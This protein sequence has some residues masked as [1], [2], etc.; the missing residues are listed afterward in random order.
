MYTT[1]FNVI[2]TNCDASDSYQLFTNPP[3]NGWGRWY[4][5]GVSKYEG[6]DWAVIDNQNNEALYVEGPAITN[7]YDQVYVNAGL[8]KV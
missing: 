4:N 3:T 2:E 7:E 8:A 5:E 6:A 1:S